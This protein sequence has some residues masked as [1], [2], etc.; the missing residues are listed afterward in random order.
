MRTMYSWSHC[1][2]EG[3]VPGGRNLDSLGDQE[4]VLSAERWGN[5]RALP[6]LS[7]LV[8]HIGFARMAVAHRNVVGEGTR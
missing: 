7:A 2:L 8:L 4:S 5:P 6:T 3:L 1:R